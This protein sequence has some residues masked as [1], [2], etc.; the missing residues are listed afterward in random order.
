VS[1]TEALQRFEQVLLQ[2]FPQPL[3]Q[4]LPGLDDGGVEELATLL[5]PMHLP[6]QVET[7]Y[8]WRNGGRVGLFGGWMLRPVKDLLSWRSFC[9]AELGEPPAWLRLFDDQ[10]L[11][12]ITLDVDA[13]R[14]ADRSVWYCH[15]H[16]GWLCRLF[17]SI[18]S[19]IHTCAD[20]AEAGVLADV[21]GRLCLDEGES[22]DGRA[23][24]PYRLQRCPGAFDYPDPP[25][26]TYI[27]RSPDPDWPPDWLA[28]LGVFP[29][30]SFPRGA[31]H[32]IAGLL[33]EAQTGPVEGTIR[34]LVIGASGVGSI[35][36]AS[37]DDGTAQ[38]SVTCDPQRVVFG[39]RMQDEFEFDVVVTTPAVPTYQ[40]EDEDPRVA[41]VMRRML[42]SA[43][44]AVATAVRPIASS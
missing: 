15:T 2:R 19:M 14:P 32:S 4:M 3:S 11:G 1:L 21:R 39:P 8:R 9:L 18:E 29:G 42:P 35:W 33:A 44:A 23:W 37:V 38:L 27:S 24:T 28:S 7:L 22:V 6:E 5:H 36:T 31:T 13:G 16:D 20:A 41:A 40:L 17:D 26:G 30:D 10:C 12:F 34:G 43:P 25:S